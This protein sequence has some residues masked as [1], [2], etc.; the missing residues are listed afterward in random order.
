[1]QEID[2]ILQKN[3]G[4]GAKTFSG[5]VITLASDVNTA[6]LMEAPTGPARPSTVYQQMQ[7]LPKPARDEIEQVCVQQLNRPEVQ[8]DPDQVAF[9]QSYQQLV[10]RPEAEACLGKSYGD[11]HMRTYD[12]YTYDLQTVGEFVFTKSVNGNFEIQTRQKAVGS[13][14]SLNSATAMQVNGDRVSIYTQDFPDNYTQYPI[15][16][17]GSPLAMSTGE[18]RLQNGGVIRFVGNDIRVT[19]PTGEQAL[20]KFFSQ[21]GKKYLNV[22]AQVF[23][24]RNSGG[25]LG[26]MGNANGL[27]TD[28]LRTQNGSTL[29]AVANFYTVDELLSNKKVTRQVRKDERRHKQQLANSFGDSWRVTS[30]S[31]LFD[32]GYGQNTASFTRYNFPKKHMT[33]TEFSRNEIREAKKICEDQGTRG[34]ALR[35]CILD[36]A[37]TRNTEFAETAADIEDEQALVHALDLNNPLQRTDNTP[38]AEPTK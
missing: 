4:K 37:A 10:T 17:N 1:M 20:V 34:D 31:S 38:A 15:R 22:V 33:L 32:Y 21:S 2:N 26:L 35:G 25:Y 23:N 13:S 7:E 5:N 24:A 28:D 18:Y 9:W 16:V 8:A 27:A 14:F 3:N 30:G 19:W 6:P 36:V 29:N 11:P 12:G